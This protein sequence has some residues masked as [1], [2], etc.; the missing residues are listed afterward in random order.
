MCNIW[1]IEMFFMDVFS[2][3]G[4]KIW[5]KMLEK[6]WFFEFVRKK[7]T[8]RFV[9]ATKFKCLIDLKLGVVI[10]NSSKSNNQVLR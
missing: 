10:Q 9:T 5:R 6:A 2:V 7:P 3:Q 4:T 1:S 8:E